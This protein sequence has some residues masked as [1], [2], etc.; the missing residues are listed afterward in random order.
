MRKMFRSI[1]QKWIQPFVCSATDDEMHD[2]I[3][4]VI[5][6]YEYTYPDWDV[7][8]LALPKEDFSERNRILQ[9]VIAELNCNL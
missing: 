1:C 5:R 7:I 2:I 9:K 6:R 4:A 8:Y 3:S